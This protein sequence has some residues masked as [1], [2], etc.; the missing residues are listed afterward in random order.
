[1]RK[2]KKNEKRSELYE[3][4]CELPDKRRAQGRM[5]AQPEIILI[6]MMAIISGETTQRGFGD[7]AKRH[8]KELVKLFKLKKKRV[9]TRRTIGRVLSNIDFEKLSEKFKAWASKNVE[10]KKGDWLCV[11]GKSIRGTISDYNSS[12]QNFVSLVSVFSQKKKE[13]L[14]A[15]KIENKKTSEVPTVRELIK[16]LDLEGVVFTIDA[17]HCKKAT[18]KTIIE[19]GNDYM[20][21]T[22]ENQKNLYKQ[23]KKT[24]K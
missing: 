10:I 13:V 14:C 17:L 24:Q 19:S 23:L 12:Y 22:K 15:Q 6:T 16:L 4:F 8:K 18:T 3:L 21:A 2:K 11:D 9:P 7:F 5:H 1:M 20:I